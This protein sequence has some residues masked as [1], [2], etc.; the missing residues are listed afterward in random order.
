MN[1]IKRAADKGPVYGVYAPMGPQSLDSAHHMFDAVMAQ[2]PGRDIKKADAAEFDA[3]IKQGL[4]VAPA[5]R[6]KAVK[7]REKWPGVLNAKEASEFA[8]KIPGEQRS[9]IIKHMDKRAWANKGFPQIGVT[10]VALTDPDVFKAAGNMLGHRVVQLDPDKM[11]EETKFK[12]GTYSAPTA[13]E[14]VGDVPLVQ[15]QYAAPDVIEQRLL[16]PTTA[17]D[18]IHPYSKSPVGRSSARK[19]FEEQKNIQPLN[20]RQLDSVMLG[21]RRQK[22]YGLKTGGAVDRAL[23]LTRK[24]THAR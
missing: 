21:L 10:R 6:A 11:G 20:Q 13:G 8:R 1:H 24:K 14:Y 2:I 22:E 4:H 7:A 15:R 12:H 5:N 3:Q 19:I 18:I 9:A 23:A 16:K 17:G